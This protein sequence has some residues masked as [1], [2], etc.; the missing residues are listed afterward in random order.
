MMEIHKGV[1]DLIVNY[2]SHFSPVFSLDKFRIPWYNINS[3]IYF[4]NIFT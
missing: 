4:I 3:R 2:T 1:S